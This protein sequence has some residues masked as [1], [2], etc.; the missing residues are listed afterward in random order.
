MS[1]NVDIADLSAMIDYMFIS[2]TPFKAPMSVG[3]VDGSPDGGIDISDL[4]RMIDYLYISFTPLSCNNRTYSG[5]ST[6]TVSFGTATGTNTEKLVPINLDNT[7]DLSGVRLKISYDTTKMKVLGVTSTPRTSLL[8]V[9]FNKDIIGIYKLDGSAVIPTGKGPIVNLRVG[10]GT[11]GFDTSALKFTLE[12]GASYKNTKVTMK[13]GT[14]TTTTPPKTITTT[15]TPKTT[16]T[17]PK[18]AITTTT[19]TSVQT[20]TTTQKKTI[21]SVI[22]SFVKN[23]FGIK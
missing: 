19:K 16:T 21:S 8:S 12:E 23:L 3:N 1:G 5:Y 10:P 6:S 13:V 15:T 4:S 14:S 17:Q 2:F 7:D 9:T 18:A 11:N 20:T 22:T